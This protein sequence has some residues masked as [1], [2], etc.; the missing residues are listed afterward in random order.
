MC[1]SLR[2]GGA[3]IGI[4]DQGPTAR[5]AGGCRGKPGVADWHHHAHLICY[6]CGGAVEGWPAAVSML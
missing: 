2:V 5:C 3:T 6:Q 1:L 4:V